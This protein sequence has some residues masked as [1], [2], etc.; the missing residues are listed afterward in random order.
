[1]LRK[2]LGRNE[3]AINTAMGHSF[4]PSNECCA[5]V[6]PLVCYPSAVEL[7]G[8][9][10][11]SLISGMVDAGCHFE[12]MQWSNDS[13]SLYRHGNDNSE[14]ILIGHEP[15]EIVTRC[16]GQSARKMVISGLTIVQ[17]ETNCNLET[18][19]WRIPGIR[20]VSQGLD[21]QFHWYLQL[22]AKYTLYL[23]LLY[24]LLGLHCYG[25]TLD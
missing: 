1:M 16:I 10:K 6:G 14:I 20:R 2:I 21:L 22:P 8:N 19:G 7:H 5:G 11:S 18:E 4:I 24:W 9:S 3:I 17:L 12:V 25:A 23:V 13:L 15:T